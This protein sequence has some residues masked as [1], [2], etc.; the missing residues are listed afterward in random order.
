MIAFF[1]T[2]PES[3]R[4]DVLSWRSTN[5]CAGL[6][7]AFLAGVLG[8]GK[9]SLHVLILRAKDSLGVLS[10]KTSFEGHFWPGIGR[11]LTKVVQICKKYA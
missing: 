3:S 4:L 10:P 1:R 2:R 5:E 6:A 9:A 8:M 11:K 7:C